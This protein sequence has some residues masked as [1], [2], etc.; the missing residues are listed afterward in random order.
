MDIEWDELGKSLPQVVLEVS[1]SLICAGFGDIA[2][3]PLIPFAEFSESKISFAIVL[4]VY[5]MGKL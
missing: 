1:Q 3:E 2:F 5:Q 4:E